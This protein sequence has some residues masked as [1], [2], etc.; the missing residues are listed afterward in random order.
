V[1]NYKSY[2]FQFI[3]V[4]FSFLNVKFLLDFLGDTD[5]ATWLIVFSVAGLIY[6]LDLGIGS[7]VRN[8]L[9]RRLAKRSDAKAQVQLVFSYYKLILI[10]AVGFFILSIILGATVYFWGG[11]Q[12]VGIGGIFIIS[13]LIFIDF[14]TR[15]H[16]PLFAGLQFPHITNLA[17][18]V[19]QIVIFLT[20]FFV[21]IPS[22]E[23]FGERLLIAS[24]LIFGASIVVNGFMVLRL[25]Q[26]IPIFSPSY[27]IRNQRFNLRRLLFQL[28]RGFPFFLVQVEFSLLGQIPLY[29]IYFHFSA[30]EVV[31][32]AIADKVFAPAIIAATI[33]MYPL[34]S[35]YT[36]LMHCGDSARVRLLLKRQELVTLAA[37]P[38]LMLSIF[39]YNEIVF[40]WLNRIINNA[41]FPF[42]AVL[43]IFSIYSNSIYSYFMNGM[44][45][46]YPQIYVYTIGLFIAIPVLYVGSFYQN[47]Y[48]CLSVTPTIL[49]VAALVQRFFVFKVYLIKK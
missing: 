24:F 35:T 46:L 9:A 31:E 45:K 3:A 30:Q 38:V 42:F 29:F 43:K 7:T 48:V 40:T 34:W 21:L 28:K 17:L 19:I 5:Y 33:I 49:L 36:H 27:S 15:A 44:G 23:S 25:N 37:L 41:I 8:Q 12:T 39:F 1:I 22:K 32:V 4:L 6:T 16:H 14:V 2:F 11:L 26:L 18:A 13:L 20:I 10:L 47:I